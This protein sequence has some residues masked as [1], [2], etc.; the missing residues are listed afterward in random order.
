MKRRYLRSRDGYN[1]AD[2]WRYFWGWVSSVVGVLAGVVMEVHVGRGAVT[3]E[4]NSCSG[5]RAGFNLLPLSLLPLPS[6]LSPLPPR[7]SP[8][9]NQQNDARARTN[10]SLRL[11]RTNLSLRVL[12]LMRSRISPSAA[13]LPPSFRL[14]LSLPLSPQR[15]KDLRE[16]T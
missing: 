1:D 15:A 5:S 14:S 6:P 9:L 8:P 7:P 11:S 3:G 16:G 13:P 10:L 12:T 2:G 4:T